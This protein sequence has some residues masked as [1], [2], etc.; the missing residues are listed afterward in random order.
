[1][2]GFSNSPECLSHCC[3]SY[4]L[5]TIEYFE[6]QNMYDKDTGLVR[7]HATCVDSQNGCKAGK[8]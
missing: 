7:L 4:I 5:R 6:S 1:M 3:T 8:Q 2:I